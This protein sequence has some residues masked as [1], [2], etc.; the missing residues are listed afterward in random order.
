MSAHGKHLIAKDLDKVCDCLVSLVATESRNDNAGELSSMMLPLLRASR[1]DN[2]DADFDVQ[3]AQRLS[4]ELCFLSQKFESCQRFVSEQYETILFNFLETLLDSNRLEIFPSCNLE[5]IAED[6]GDV[7]AQRALTLLDLFNDDLSQGPHDESNRRE[8]GAMVEIQQKRRNRAEKVWK[9]CQALGSSLTKAEQSQVEETHHLQFATTLGIALL[10]RDNDLSRSPR[11]LHNSRSLE[12]ETLDCFKLLRSI[13]SASAKSDDNNSAFEKISSFA[14]SLVASHV[15]R[16]VQSLK[17]HDQ[18]C[19]SGSQ[20]SEADFRRVKIGE[21]LASYSELFIATVAWILRENQND[22][23]E[24]WKYLQSQIR[25]RL[26]SPVLR[27]QSIDFTVCL[28][29][30]VVAS[31]L[32]LAGSSQKSTTTCTGLPGCSQYLLGMFDKIIRR[33]RQLILAASRASQNLSLQSFLVEAVIGTDAVH[34]DQAAWLVGISFKSTKSSRN[35]LM[36]R[37]PL[38][39][40]IDEYLWFVE[41]ELSTSS[42]LLERIKKTKLEFIKTFVLPRVNQKKASLARKRKVLRLVAYILETDADRTAPPDLSSLNGDI[43][44]SLVKGIRSTLFQCLEKSVV[45]DHFVSVVFVCSVSL[46]NLTI[47]CEGNT[48]SLIGWGREVVNASVNKSAAKLCKTEMEAIYLWV[49]FKWLQSLGNLIA[50]ASDSSTDKLLSYRKERISKDMNKMGEEVLFVNIDLDSLR[51]ENND[52]ETWGSILRCTENHLFPSRTENNPNIV[53][54]YA[55]TGTS[56][57]TCEGSLEPWAPSSSVRR[58][59]KEFMA[60]VVSMS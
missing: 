48:Q 7:A 19:A 55:K 14:I 16:I 59:A 60:E 39:K 22:G 29:Q 25:D 30:I 38:E 12:K 2:K 40:D 43:P 8:F 9:Y 32:V 27:R 46:A 56:N 21:L 53:N 58:T 37:S 3:I 15:L 33:S 50:D 20:D 49:F 23:T 13:I 34:E 10:K 45:D 31:R 41:Q 6:A 26:I 52:L 1:D 42:N 17:Y 18:T 44:S 24:P 47:E 28:Q 57:A 4:S 51:Q 35:R 5:R 54:V 11:S 36:F